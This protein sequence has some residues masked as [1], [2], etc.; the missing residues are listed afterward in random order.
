MTRSADPSRVR[1]YGDKWNDGVVQVSFTLPLPA[2]ARA[3]E[4]A[5]QYVAKMGI[6]EPYVALA[7]PIAPEFTFFVVYGR[8]SHEVDA[9]AIVTEEVEGA[10]MSR[11]EID[12][13]IG[14]RF[15]RR[16][17]VFGCAL[18]SDA[19]SVG[20]DAIFNPK[21]FS[22]DYGLERYANLDARNL[23]AQVPVETV[24]RIARE[25]AADAL[26]VSAT[27]DA[28]RDP[29]AASDGSRGHARGGGAPGR[30][31]PRGG[32]RAH[33][34]PARQGA[35]LRR[36]LRARD[37]ALARCGVPPRAGVPEDAAGHGRPRVSERVLLRLRVGVEDVHYGG[38]LVDGA[39]VLK[40]FGDAATELLIRRDGDEGLF[41]AYSSVD[42]LAPVRGGDYLEVEAEITR[43][44]KTSREIRF[45]ARKVISSTAPG[46]SSA[47]VLDPPVVVARA[48]GTCVVPVEKQ[49]G[50]A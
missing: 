37:D 9:S 27:V 14:N 32:R 19:H 31:H 10:A 20:I 24:V 42:F 34:S 17:V 41:R 22:G 18:E 30:D 21:G 23:G 16:L 39:Y 3:T 36:G 2:S 15:G 26:L 49:R 12:A 33:R 43:A 13:E 46:S 5:R 48:T 50:P 28:E 40:L 35:R 11:D 7:Q 38:G 4:A 8:A 6:R 29:R 25:A 45:E 1:A 44:G 47:R